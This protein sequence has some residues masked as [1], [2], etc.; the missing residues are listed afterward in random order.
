M[1]FYTE[2]S[3]LTSGFSVNSLWTYTAISGRDGNHDTPLR[4]IIGKTLHPRLQGVLSKETLSNL[5]PTNQTGFERH[6]VIQHAIA[7][8]LEFLCQGCA[9]QPPSR[10]IT[11][12]LDKAFNKV[13]HES[14]IQT[15]TDEDMYQS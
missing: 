2:S 13:D 3:G 6:M 8:L 1:A 4:K 9:T 11:L 15:L 5:I 7:F 12:D 10:L 14:L